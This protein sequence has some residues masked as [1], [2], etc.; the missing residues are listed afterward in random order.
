[1]WGPEENLSINF[2]C[3]G[4]LWRSLWEGCIVLWGTSP[5]KL[6]LH[7]EAHLL[8]HALD[9]WTIF[10]S[11]SLSDGILLILLTSLLAFALCKSALPGL[12]WNVDILSVQ[13][14]K[15]V[16]QSP[17]ALFLTRFWCF[18]SSLLHYCCYYLFTYILLLLVTVLIISYG[19]FNFFQ[20]PFQLGLSKIDFRKM[21][22]SSLSGVSSWILSRIPVLFLDNYCLNN[23]VFHDTGWQIF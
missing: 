20:I 18:E 12:R 10:S 16:K 15:I 5:M 8:F 17:V 21:L 22:K 3:L 2:A 4:F 14:Y 23:W 6:L 9:S 19:W 13:G 11:I 1:M 7:R